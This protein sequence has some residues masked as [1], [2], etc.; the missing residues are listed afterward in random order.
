MHK[1]GL[2]IVK[3]CDIVAIK[4]YGIKPHGHVKW[5]IW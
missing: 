3:H 5:H 1:Y 4:F 2:F